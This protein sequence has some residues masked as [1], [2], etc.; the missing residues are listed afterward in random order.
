M[1]RVASSYCV[2]GVGQGVGFDCTS[3]LCRRHRTGGYGQCGQI[4]KKCTAHCCRR[5]MS[6]N[7]RHFASSVTN[8]V[9]EDSQP[10]DEETKAGTWCFVITLTASYIGVDWWTAFTY[11]ERKECILELKKSFHEHLG[12]DRGDYRIQAVEKW[13]ENEV[14]RLHRRVEFQ[15]EVP[16]WLVFTYSI[17]I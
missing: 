9:W 10:R 1:C 17:H 15:S 7:S 6:R 12:I 4:G 14:S 5:D 8:R 3:D 2:V 11:Q 13:F 16:K